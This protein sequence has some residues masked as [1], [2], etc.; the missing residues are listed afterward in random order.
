MSWFEQKKNPAF[1]QNNAIKKKSIIL[2]T[3]PISF[4]TNMNSCSTVHQKQSL[5][6]LQIDKVMLLY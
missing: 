2:T 5:K 3:R 4:I 6:S 1:G